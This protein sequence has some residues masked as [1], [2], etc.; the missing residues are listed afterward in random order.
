MCIVVTAASREFGNRRTLSVRIRSQHR[1]LCPSARQTERQRWILFYFV[2]NSSTC[3]PGAVAPYS[4]TLILLA[5]AEDL[6]SLPF[7]RHR[8]YT[9]TRLTSRCFLSC[10]PPFSREN[11]PFVCSM[12]TH[13]CSHYFNG[14]RYGTSS[15]SSCC[16]VFVRDSRR[17]LLLLQPRRTSATPAA[18]EADKKRY[19]T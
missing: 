14:S 12:V 6:S 4:H 3:L 9:R 2:F 17:G 15:Q 1:F 16:S 7:P 10:V 8:H 18:R 13:C 19:Y 11:H 5:A